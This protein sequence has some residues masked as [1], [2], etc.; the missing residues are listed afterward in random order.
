MNENS[1]LITRPEHDE[2]TYYLSKWS[3]KSISLAKKKGLKVMDLLRKKANKKEVESRLKKQ[4]P[5]LVVFTGH[6]NKNEIFGYRNQPL[7]SLG[8]NEKLLIS[9]I[10]YS[11]SCESA[12]KLGLE[13]I[14]AGAVNYTGYKE[15]FFLVFE[16]EKF[17][18]PL[19]DKT[20]KLF[21]NPSALF[22][23][24]I[25]KGNR[26]EDAFKKSKKL[27]KD[28]FRLSLSIDTDSSRFLWW[29]L[30]NFNSYGDM[31]ASINP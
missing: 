13:S 3:E 5:R 11:I 6:G 1:Y 7:I 14:K 25:I 22:I 4:N 31:S 28:N 19:N 30:Q 8:K 29:N 27:M 9:K 10:I 17:S 24:S 20:A 12:K 2:A 21:L 15:D 16:P 18:R 23:E 26:I